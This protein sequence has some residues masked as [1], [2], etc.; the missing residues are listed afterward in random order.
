MEPDLDPSAI[1]AR[2]GL[3]N[4]ARVDGAVDRGEV[5][6]V[7]PLRTDRGR[8]AVKRGNERQNVTD[9]EATTRVQDAAIANGVASPTA[10][11]P[12]DGE[13]LADVAGSQVRVHEWVDLAPMSRDL[14]VEALGTMLARVHTS[15]A[16]AGA[17]DPWYTEPITAAQWDARDNQIV[18][19]DWDSAGA[20]DPGH[21][22]SMVLWEYCREAPG[23]APGLAAA[24]RAAGGPGRLDGPASFSMMICISSR[25][26]HR[27]CRIWL[28]PASSAAERAF[29]EFDIADWIRDPC[30]RPVIDTLLDAVGG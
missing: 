16:T 30:T 18:V 5:G 2:F 11:R 13:L 24:Y 6:A 4:D 1:A 12:T 9:V 14:D 29:R 19:I 21:E 22:L 26:L 7:W 25:L 17:V 8:W 20:T 15:G 23:R 27:S 10:I 28:D 3:G